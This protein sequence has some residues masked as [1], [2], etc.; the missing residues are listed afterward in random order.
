MKL[1]HIFQKAT[2]GMTVVSPSVPDQILRA[3]KNP[4]EDRVDW[5]RYYKNDVMSP[6]VASF[7]AKDFRRDDYEVK[8]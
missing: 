4:F 3:V 7:T 8:P 1:E 6:Q 2:D 5:L